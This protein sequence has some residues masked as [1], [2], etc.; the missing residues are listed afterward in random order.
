MHG[1][2]LSQHGSMTLWWIL[3]IAVV[4]TLIWRLWFRRSPLSK[5]DTAD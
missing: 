2:D 4:V 5:T 1:W 3:A